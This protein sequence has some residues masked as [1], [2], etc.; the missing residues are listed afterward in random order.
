[1]SDSLRDQLLKAGLATKGQ[2]NRAKQKTRKQK[3]AAKERPADTEAARLAKQTSAEVRAKAAKDRALNKQR[4]QRE[5]LL[6]MDNTVRQLVERHGVKPD[7]NGDAYNFTLDGKV[8]SLP[9]S[10]AQRGQIAA[11]KLAIVSR[12][13]VHHLVPVEIADRIAEQAPEW[14]WK[15]EP[16]DAAP[17]PDD[18]YAAYQVPDD[19]IW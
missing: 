9:V 15:I 2:A 18:P 13:G 11:G 8:R 5:K 17:D 7:A 4:A 19:L 1:M 6:D 14:V 3:Q 12:A 10:T 16:D